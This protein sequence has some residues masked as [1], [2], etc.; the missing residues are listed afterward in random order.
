M[1]TQVARHNRL[2]L[3]LLGRADEPGD[4]DQRLLAPGLG[5]LHREL[6]HRLIQTGLADGE[7]GGVHAHRQAA[8]AGVQVVARER[9]LAAPVEL[10]PGVEHKQVRRDHSPKVQ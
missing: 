5:G 2:A 3:C 4:H 7:L 9:A 1:I 10:A 6:Q 8:R